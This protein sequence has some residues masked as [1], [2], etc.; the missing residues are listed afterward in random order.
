MA[1]TGAA[2]LAMMVAACTDGPSTSE[3]STSA[4]VTTA[5]A[6]SSGPATTR[7]PEWEKVVPGD[8][9]ECADGSEF[10]FWV[11]PAD[12][13]KVVL[14]LDGGG[15]CWDATTCAFTDEESTTYDWNISAD[16]DPALEHGIFELSNPDNPFAGYSFVYVPHC[17]GDVHL[18]DVTREYSP[19]V[20]VEHNGFV[21]GTAALTYLTESF[22]DAEQVVVVG[23]SSGSV[24]APVYAGLTSDSLPEA[25]V[26]VLADSSGAYPDDPELNADILGQWDTFETMPDWEVNDGLT[27]KEWA[28]PRF[29]VQAGLHDPEIVMARFDYANDERQA[30]M[31][32]LAGVDASNLIAS[33]DANEAAIE[34]AGVTQHSYTAAGSDHGIVGDG[35]FY[36][37]EVDGITLVDWV[38]ALLGGEPP[39]D[40]HCEQCQP[41]PNTVDTG[42]ERPDDPQTADLLEQLTAVAECMRGKGYTMA[43]P[44][45]DDQGHVYLLPPLDDA[46][47]QEEIERQD[48][49]NNACAAQAGLGPPATDED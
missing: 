25:R 19:E 13:T 29:W 33:I 37:M 14:F 41:T 48:A 1:A 40:V 5:A 45:I 10:A 20:T 2:A 22:P 27:A 43:D 31:M 16:D 6:T 42:A 23:E 3:P 8:G 44:S 9:C 35:S 28:I 36:R 34:R 39:D 15:A 11:R 24:A 49:D 32:E 4:P 18:G 17:T 38:Q 21:N 30:S 47:S 46:G 7:V 26:A 12:P